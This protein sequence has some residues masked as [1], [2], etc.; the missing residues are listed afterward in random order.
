MGEPEFKSL[1]GSQVHF[2]NLHCDFILVQMRLWVKETQFLKGIVCYF[3]ILSA[4]HSLFL[5]P[6][7]KNS[8]QKHLHQLSTIRTFLTRVREVATSI[9]LFHCGVWS[10]GVERRVSV[11]EGLSVESVS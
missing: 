7:L 6:F 1:S 4:F 8:D 9:V 2:F 10:L 11:E 5:L 3:L